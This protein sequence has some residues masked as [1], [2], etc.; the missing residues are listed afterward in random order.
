MLLRE[1]PYCLTLSSYALA[2]TTLGYAP[3]RLHTPCPFPAPLPPTRCAVLSS[4]RRKRGRRGGAAVPP[5]VEA[6]AA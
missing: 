5:V 3:T 1:I 4:G 6:L 2:P